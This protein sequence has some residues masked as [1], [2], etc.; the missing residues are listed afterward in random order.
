LVDEALKKLAAKFRS[1][2]DEGPRMVADV[3]EVIGDA[4]AIR[5]LTVYTRVTEF[6]TLCR[7]QS[8]IGNTQIAAC[9]KPDTRG[10]GGSFG[11]R[12]RATERRCHRRTGAS[13]SRVD[14][15]K[16]PSARAESGRGR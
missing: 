4:R 9:F 11:G 14:S 12:H 8:S 7:Y 16:T 3:E 5:K 6:L 10:E 2:E 1:E 13:D 15:P